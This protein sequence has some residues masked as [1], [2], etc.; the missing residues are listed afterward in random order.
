MA[1]TAVKTVFRVVPGAK[2]K[3]TDIQRIGEVFE[4]LK[5][6]GSGVLTAAR[7]V[8]EA[9]NPQSPLHAYFQWDNRKAAH[10]YR[11]QQAQYLLR[12][13]EVVIQEKGKAVA[14]RAFYPVTDRAGVRA[15]EPM[16]YV[17]E[18]PD[19]AAQVIAQAYTQ[20]QGW[21]LRHARYEWAQAV[22]PKIQEVLR[23]LAQAQ[24]A[25]K[26][27]PKAPKMQKPV[28]APKAPRPK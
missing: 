3:R 17:F 20:L 19:L 11:L 18:R 12:S 8:Q 22:I 6:S 14:L 1:P 10:A 21:V 27:A 28:P 24:K 9:I 23:D 13:I 4:Q 26:L 2:I 5:A 25:H 7:V 15:Y 16:T